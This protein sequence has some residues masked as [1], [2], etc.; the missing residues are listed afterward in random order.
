MHN[1][2]GDARE[3][4][5]PSRNASDAFQGVNSLPV[6]STP[7]VGRHKELA[8]LKSM[9][10][11]TDVP[12]L[13]L[14]GPGGIGKTRLAL[15]L[16]SDLTD[17]FADGVAFVSLAALRDPELVV[18]AIAHAVDLHEGAEGAL[19]ERLKNHLRAQLRLLVLDNFE[20]LQVASW[21]VTELL[22][23]CPHVKIL[24]TSRAPLRLSVEQAYPVPPLPAPD[25]S[26]G[27]TVTPEKALHFDAVQLFQRRVQAVKPAFEL[28]DDNAAT[29]AEICRKLDGLPLAIELAAARAKLFPP[30][31]LLERLER[32]LEFLT[33]GA[34][35]LPVRHQMLRSTIEWSYI[36]LR[37]EEKALFRC[38]AV[39]DGGATL[40]AIE[41]VYSQTGAN[42]LDALTLLVEHNLV[43]QTES[44]DG[45]VRFTM[46]E[47]IRE[48]ALEKLS[49]HNELLNVQREHADY[50]LTMAEQSATGLV[51]PEQ[52]HWLD[53]LEVEHNN[54]RAVLRFLLAERS[55]EK[56]LRLAGSLSRFW[57]MKGSLREAQGWLEQVLALP[58]HPVALMHEAANAYRSLGIIFLRQGDP[59]NAE[60][61]GREALRLCEET[62]DEPGAALARVV[63][64]QV[65][66]L[67]NPRDATTL[68]EQALQ[69]YQ[70]IGDDFGV[71]R[72]YQN[73]ATNA[74]YCEDY[75]TSLAYGGQSITYLR[76]VGSEHFLSYALQ[77]RASAACYLG[78]TLQARVDLDEAFELA[79]AAGDRYNL[80]FVFHAL[81]DTFLRQGLPYEATQLLAASRDL[82][83]RVGANHTPVVQR[84]TNKLE[85]A[86]MKELDTN[87]FRSAWAEGEKLSTD[88]VR[89]LLERHPPTEQPAGHAPTEVPFRLTPRELE[90]LSVLSRGYSDRRI[91]KELGISPA[92]VSRHV[93]NIL[94][95]TNLKNRTALAV[96]ARECG[97]VPQSPT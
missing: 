14:T 79:C 70:A 19:H 17:D 9:L 21:I 86:L 47:T 37:E 49:E 20:H 27:D 93:L 66:N 72:A 2:A 43:Q 59:E 23:S 40:P 89:A 95:K 90:V 84:I 30:K 75:E 46:L 97:L 7:F 28:T 24:V 82:F 32:K 26:H 85:E 22:S 55:T 25:G 11:R 65:V 60:V 29:V 31:A 39:F 16:A 57:H 94:S 63:L 36:L 80:S 87:V 13:T 8:V 4:F 18:P 3:P 45:E 5:E 64:G 73:L 42:V 53:L 50:F 67:N 58:R 62:K 10:L 35:D 34:Q 96:W 78:N 92:T 41:T 56:A 76:K 61:A 91:A 33:M 71:G 69:F 74:F 1:E 15:R 54:F 44:A 81:S 51:G 48:Y 68:F 38:F 6:R 83:R 12:L 77:M 52:N 88:D